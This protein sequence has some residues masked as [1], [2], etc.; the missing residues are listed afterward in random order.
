MNPAFATIPK[1]DPIQHGRTH[2]FEESASLSGIEDMG[3]RSDV[4]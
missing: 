2:R 3:A 4:H 1:L